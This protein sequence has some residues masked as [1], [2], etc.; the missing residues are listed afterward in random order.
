MTNFLWNFTI[1]AVVSEVDGSKKG[2]VSNVRCNGS[3]QFMP[4]YCQG[5]DSL[6]VAETCNPMPVAE[7]TRMIP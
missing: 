6:M 3:T 1:K 4:L 7:L 2:E 5:R